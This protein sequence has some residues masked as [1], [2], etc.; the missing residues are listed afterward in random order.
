M[1]DINTK[2]ILNIEINDSILLNKVTNLVDE[3]SLS[4]DEFVL[5]STNKLIYDIECT[6]KLRG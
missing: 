5:Y 6:R 4:M 1:S 2:I 3:L